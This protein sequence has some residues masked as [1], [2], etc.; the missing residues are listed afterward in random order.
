MAE[1]TS[2]NE[3]LGDISWEP[4]SNPRLFR[5]AP[6]LFV[7]AQLGGSSLAVQGELHQVFQAPHA[8]DAKEIVHIILAKKPGASYVIDIGAGDGKG[9]GANTDPVYEVFKKFDLPGISVEADPQNAAAL[10]QN[11]PSDKIKK[12]TGVKVTP[13]NVAEILKGAGAP[14]EAL[15]L[16]VK[17]KAYDCSLVQAVLAAGFRPLAIHMQVNPE[18]PLPYVFGVHYDEGFQA[19]KQTGGFYG[20]SVGLVDGLLR[21]HDYHPVAAGG[22]HEV[23]YVQSSLLSRTG[24]QFQEVPLVYIAAAVKSSLGSFSHFDKSPAGPAWRRVPWETPSDAIDK[25]QHALTQ[26]CEA[27]Q[28]KSRNVPMRRA[29]DSMN[30][31]TQCG[32]PFTISTDADVFLSRALGIAARASYAQSGGTSWAEEGLFAALVQ[33]TRSQL[34]QMKLQQMSAYRQFL[35]DRNIEQVCEVGFDAGYSALALLTAMKKSAT[36]TS[37]DAGN[38]EYSR[39]AATMLERA[40]PGQF[41]MVWGDTNQTLPEASQHSGP[42]C[43]MAVVDETHMDPPRNALSPHMELANLMFLSKLNATVVMG[44]TNCTSAWCAGP[45]KAWEDAVK[46]GWVRPIWSTEGVSAGRFQPASKLRSTLILFFVLALAI[47]LAIGLVFLGKSEATEQG[48][49]LKQFA[50][51]ASPLLSLV[52]SDAPLAPRSPPG[53]K[54]EMETPALGGLITIS[55]GSWEGGKD[56]LL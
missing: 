22:T 14:R 54:E 23:V 25:A 38:H 11:L 42:L 17:V 51:G 7:K 13:L 1:F 37:F 2:S 56:V 12:V 34:S 5:Y 48:N 32:V 20:C 3:I 49:L 4:G 30:A 9:S 26:S 46:F 10:V 31:A 50:F 35:Q 33:T 28:G 36:L 43:D 44:D 53:R 52:L 18:V 19:K 6:F 16:K 45:T 27:V 39:S 21:P 47:G 41:S 29:H 55:D 8:P 15:Y 40:F 24:G